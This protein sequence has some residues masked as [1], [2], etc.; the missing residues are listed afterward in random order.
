MIP[1]E[2]DSGSYRDPSGRIFYE[3]DTVFRTVT[4]HGRAAYETSRD[5]A[6]VQNMMADGQL[7]ASS[8]VA[9]RD[10]WP[11][12][13]DAAYVLQHP[14]IPVISYP[15]E[16]SFS[17]LKAAALHHLDMHLTLLDS[18]L[19]L[20]DATAYNIQF[21]GS[22]PVFIDRLSI[23][24]YVNGSLWLGHKQFCEQFLNPLLLR[25]H[26]DIPHNDWFRGSLEGI[27]TKHLASLLPLKSYLS[28]NLLSHVLL[29]A[30]LDAKSM[31]S[32]NAAIEKVHAGN[33]LP[34][35][36]LIGLLRQLRNWIARLKP[37]GGL[38][39]WGVYAEDN[40][41]SDEEAVRKAA[42]IA[43]FAAKVKPGRLVDLGCNSGN[44]S[45]AA[46]QG[47][48]E[49]VTGYDFDQNALDRAYQRAAQE[50]LN[51]LPLWLDASNPSPDQ[52]WNQSERK[53]F[54]H[55]SRCDAVIALAFE[56][57]LAIAKNVP[58]RDAV[59]WI[60]DIAPVGIIEF[61]PKSDPTVQRM[62]ALREDIFHE[63]SID[64][65]R[66]AIS[67]RAE[68]VS[69]TVISASGRT[70]FWFKAHSTR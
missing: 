3:G 18:G 15:Y 36:G 37:K 20:S 26:F 10:R 42:F 51:F 59:H 40:T 16:W 64:T 43:D 28:W 4:D 21:I 34:K 35:L 32:P 7:I 24:P 13:K 55:R 11:H 66:N 65:F 57:H 62:L 9:F 25:A 30:K 67:E 69:E 44:Y 12:L 61:V 29:P 63:Y 22:K 46:L 5:S 39:V 58:L 23:V 53:G 48:A 27:A 56:H 38:S 54:A 68:I 19:S 50:K 8:E 41:Y 6:I 70:L 45:L 2:F 31:S 1:G 47:G 33:T 49:H 14:R 60:M 17:Q 52:G